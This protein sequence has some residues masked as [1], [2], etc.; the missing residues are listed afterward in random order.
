MYGLTEA[1]RSTYLA[2][3]LVATH[4]DSIGTAIP[5]AEVMVVRDDGESAA[6]GEVGEMVHA[7]PLVAQGYWQ[8]AMRTAERFKPA[9]SWSKS[10]GMAVWSGDKV[11]ADA[12]GLLRFIGRDDE[13]IKTSG[14]RVSPAEIEEAA[15]ASGVVAEAIAFGRADERLGAVIIL[16]VRGAGV[17]AETTLRAH[18]KAELPVFMQ[19][20]EIHWREEFPR[21]PNGKL[22]RSAIKREMAG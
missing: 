16:V 5:F 1:F 9:P 8:D 2:P 21:N 3:H 14:N 17:D 13:M 10:G 20:A 11:V 22:D 4:P 18:L 15:L 12:Q 7:G 6:P 19:P